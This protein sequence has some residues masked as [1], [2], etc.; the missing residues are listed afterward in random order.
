VKVTTR[1]ILALAIGLATV[2]PADARSPRFSN[3]YDGLWHLSF[4]TRTGS[5]DPSYDFDVNVSNGVITHPN[6]VRFRGK[7][8]RSGAVRASVTVQD[9][10]AAGSGRLSGVSG[11]GD[12]EGP[13]WSGC[14]R[15]QLD[16]SER[17]TRQG[18]PCVH[19]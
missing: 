12:V 4:V 9:K 17:L 6:L 2:G 7:V 16:G 18:E 3:S 19:V 15:R 14:L 5:C 1:W 13:Q 10:F 11:R 8:A